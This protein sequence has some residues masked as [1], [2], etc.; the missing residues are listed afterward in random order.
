[1]LESRCNAALKRSKMLQNL[2]CRWTKK[3]ASIAMLG[4]G[5]SDHGTLYSAITRLLLEPVEEAKIHSRMRNEM[6]DLDGPLEMLRTWLSDM[7]ESTVPHDALELYQQADKKQKRIEEEISDAM[8]KYH[9]RM[10][11][12]GRIRQVLENNPVLITAASKVELQRKE[13]RYSEK[14]VRSKQEYLNILSQEREARQSYLEHI[15]NSA[16]NRASL[17]RM[18][19]NEEV[20]SLIDKFRIKIQFPV[21]EE[22]DES[23]FNIMR[24]RDP[25]SKNKE[26]KMSRK[27]SVFKRKG[28]K[29]QPYPETSGSDDVN[30]AILTVPDNSGYSYHDERFFKK[31]FCVEKDEVST[32]ESNSVL[33]HLQEKSK[34]KDSVSDAFE[35]EVETTIVSRQA[36][37][38]DKTEKGNV[39]EFMP[40]SSA[41]TDGSKVPSPAEVTILANIRVVATQSYQAQTGTEL[42]FRQGQVI[43]QKVPPNSKGMA[44]GWTKP[45]KISRKQYGFYPASMVQVKCKKQSARKGAEVISEK[46]DSDHDSKSPSPVD[47]ST[48][49]NVKVV[50]VE[51]YHAQTTDELSLRK[52]QSINQSLPANSN[53]MSYGWT[54]ASK[55]SRKQYGFYPASI[56]QLKPKKNGIRSLLSKKS[57]PI[58]FS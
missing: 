50:A 9:Y 56:V 49:A 38:A 10:Q 6:V 55:F 25:T 16:E 15:K 11:K 48:W 41:A 58:I 34:N 28:G 24:L 4:D 20:Y 42:S 14:A 27:K 45:S 31:T 26:A 43:K 51:S 19:I 35:R 1:M 3:F 40:E 17:A 46:S 36:F 52:G 32:T 57:A 8:T 47:I 2:S 29:I 37:N 7:T 12:L 22:F 5:D 13:A 54:K 44:Y 18:N 21:Y 39:A 23:I 53:G 30:K 33:P